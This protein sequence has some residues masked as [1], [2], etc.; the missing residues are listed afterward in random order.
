MEPSKQS[1]PSL[2]APELLRE[3]AQWLAPARSR[4]LRRVDIAHKRNILDL[5]AGYGFV[6]EELFRRR[7]IITYLLKQ[8]R[9]AFLLSSKK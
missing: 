6:S 5:G 4:M 9:K 8:I 3:Q 1:N 2:P 7:I